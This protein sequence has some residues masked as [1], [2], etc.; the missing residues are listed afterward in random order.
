V[1]RDL[2]DAGF[3]DV[4]PIAGGFNVMVD[5]NHFVLKR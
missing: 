2:R 5:L 1:A 3:P 4:R